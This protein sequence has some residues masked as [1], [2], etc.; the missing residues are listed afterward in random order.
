MAAIFVG[1]GG[2]L[3]FIARLREFKRAMSKAPKAQGTG[4]ATQMA[5]AQQILV[6]GHW[7]PAASLD[8]YR[9]TSR[10]LVDTQVL[11][12]F[13][14]GMT[15]VAVTVSQAR[16]A[17]E[18]HEA[19]GRLP[20]RAVACCPDGLAWGSPECSRLCM[21]G[22]AGLSSVLTA[23][24]GIVCVMIA[25]LMFIPCE[26]WSPITFAAVKKENDVKMQRLLH[27]PLPLFV[28][29]SVNFVLFGIY[30][31]RL[32]LEKMMAHRL[33]WEV[34]CV[35]HVLLFVAEVLLL[36][37]VMPWERVRRIP[38]GVCSQLMALLPVRSQVVPEGLPPA[39]N[40]FW[41][42]RE[43]SRYRQLVLLFCSLFAF[44]ID[45][46]RADGTS[47]VEIWIIRVICLVLLGLC[48]DEPADFKMLHHTGA[49]FGLV[50]DARQLRAA[51]PGPSGR[52]ALH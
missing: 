42:C 50:V 46:L 4:L 33:I 15:T 37:W 3:V 30:T 41:L 48:F 17:V 52:A 5:P 45:V 29:I 32:F 36:A 47:G 10:L 16:N 22:N 20:W 40:L 27:L 1:L 8:S 21:L 14:V 7:T 43:C 34:V 26:L 28:I 6:Q 49:A 12:L 18:A 31:V 39:G 24:V 38:A 23:T 11:V 25:S 13:L 9:E 2:Y 51:P 44:G 19:E 35:V